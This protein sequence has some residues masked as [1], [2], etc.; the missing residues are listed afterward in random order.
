[1][2]W[3]EFARASCIAAGFVIFT[4]DEPY[5]MAWDPDRG[6]RRWTQRLE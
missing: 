2:N 5:G 3:D 6:T 4:N 1:M